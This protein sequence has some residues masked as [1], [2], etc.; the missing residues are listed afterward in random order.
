M[1]ILPCLARGP[2]T[3]TPNGFRPQA[4]QKHVPLSTCSGLYISGLGD[5]TIPNDPRWASLKLAHR[6]LVDASCHTTIARPVTRALVI[7]RRKDRIGHEGSPRNRSPGISGRRIRLSLVRNVCCRLLFPV[8]LV[9]SPASNRCWKGCAGV[10]WHQA[11]RR[12]TSPSHIITPVLVLF[13]ASLLEPM[14]EKP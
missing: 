6:R 13:S 3:K 4:T 9:Q 2:V 1:V 12:E 8:N 5:R 7:G 11:H 14:G 10:S